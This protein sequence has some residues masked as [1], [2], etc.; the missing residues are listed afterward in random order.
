MYANLP[1][2]P[3]RKTYPID[4]FSRLTLIVVIGALCVVAV[5]GFFAGY[6][7]GQR[8]TPNPQAIFNEVWRITD[9][10]FY[11][12]KPTE[13]E[14]AYAAINGLL[15]SLKDPHTIFLPPAPAAKQNAVMRGEEGGVGATVAQLED[16]RFQVMEVRRGWP[17]E[18]AGGKAG[19]VILAVDGAEIAG[20]T[21]EQVVSKIRGPL[22]TPVRLTLARE[23]SPDPIEITPVRQQINVYGEMW[24]DRIGY[25]S[26]TTFNATAPADMRTQLEKI[27]AA[28]PRA[29][30]LD[31]R[32]NTGGYLTESLEIADLFLS[33]GLIATERM[34]DGSVRRFEA[35]TG[36]IAEQVPVV[37]LVN[38]MSAS[39]SEI[40]AGA[41]QDRK[42]G[43]LIG[44]R[45]FGKGSVQRIFS[46]GDGS[47]LFVTAGAWYTPNE[48]PIQKHGDQPGGLK[49][50]IEVPPS[51][52]GA[53]VQT[54]PVEQ[55]AIDYIKK[56]F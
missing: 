34:K 52:S 14:R 55:A 48:T 25:L 4:T 7:V 46:F 44:Q 2:Q 23:G 5:G 17:F 37:V 47:Q 1:N 22:G 9:R 32:G 10:E 21:L 16:K 43:V 50:D 39:A 28:N 35:K 13:P 15:S 33:E 42:R 27:M 12:D 11:Y 29:L 19:D 8:N 31:L 6:V 41:I 40:V 20:L 51:T 45:T 18:R 24:E 38:G 49:P 26:L 3:D 56:N 54:D 53:L 30:I 36:E